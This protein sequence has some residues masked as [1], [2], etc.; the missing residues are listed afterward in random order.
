MHAYRFFKPNTIGLLDI[1]QYSNVN[2]LLHKIIMYNTILI[3]NIF[4]FN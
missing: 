1:F 4:V 3:F 2:I